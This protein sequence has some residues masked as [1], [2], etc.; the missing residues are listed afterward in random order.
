MKPIQL[1]A[2]I[3]AMNGIC[4]NPICEYVN[5]VSID[6]REELDGK[7][8][9]A[10]KGESFDGHSFVEKAF[11]NGCSF[12]V[13]N[14]SYEIP[15]SLQSQCIIVV[16]DTLKA[17]QQLAKYYLSTM[18]V[19]KIALTGSVGKTTTREMLHAVFSTKYNTMRNIKNF[20]NEFGIP[21]TIFR[22][23]E[24]HE[25]VIFEM[26]MNHFGEIELLADLV[27][28]NAAV[29]T[30]VGTA[31]IE[32]LGSREGILKAK[33]EVTKYLADQAP[34][35]INYDD[36]MLIQKQSEN[37]LFNLIKVGKHKESNFVITEVKSTSDTGIYF[38]LTY[39]N[40]KTGFSL[41]VP[42]E[43]NAYNGALAVA[44]GVAFGITMEEAASGI[45]NMTMEGKRLDIKETPSGIKIID[46]TYNANPDS[47][48][49]ALK[50]L[51]TV[52]GERKVAILGDM[53]EMGNF[54]EEGHR[55]V[56]RFATGMGTDVF[57]T[58]GN[59]ARCIGE[60]VKKAHCDA[61]VKHFDNKEIL[62]TS[63]GQYISAKDVI[64]VKGSRGMK[65]DEVVK[66]IID[67]Y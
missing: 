38:E 4:H 17:F 5:G 32:N 64:L 44:T 59:Y 19:L 63:L 16:E 36:D 30:N 14:K 24:E 58:V 60:E 23:E 3:E 12:A 1:N 31:H 8:F 52:K 28:P 61:T 40:K 37:N 45:Q 6:S 35:I 67:K 65:M 27:R 56:G 25:A 57:L 22:V 42:G 11:D 51:T 10:L 48:K 18:N 41:P 2:A 26:G 21:L 29:I 50:V 9:F 46:D 53:F 55:E 20:N 39:E 62:Y 49:A 15:D 54:S 47:M 13:V 34:V 7:G 66:H 43:H 33:W